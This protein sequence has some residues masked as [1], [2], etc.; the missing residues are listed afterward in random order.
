MQSTCTL[1]HI[2]LHIY[3]PGLP[4]YDNTTVFVDRADEAYLEKLAEVKGPCCCFQF[5]NWMIFARCA[6]RVP[7]THGAGCNREEFPR[8]R[9][10]FVPSM[11][12]FRIIHTIA[13]L[14]PTMK[15][16]ATTSYV[17]N[18]CSTYTFMAWRVLQIF[19]TRANVEAVRLLL[20]LQLLKPGDQIFWLHPN[21]VTL[22]NVFIDIK[23]SLVF[24]I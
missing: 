4:A 16:C 12:T 20:L 6:L 10:R 8:L 18:P 24:K 17:L 14:R 7:Q 21:M 9:T 19:S 13:S 22:N 11:L 2:L 5:L 23:S 1:V 15:K 3:V